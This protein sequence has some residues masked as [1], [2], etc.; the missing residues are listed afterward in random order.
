MT[1]LLA[2]AV[3]FLFF[4]KIIFDPNNNY[5]S[6]D[7]DGFKAYYGAIY[8]AKYDTSLMRMNGM[9][10][11]YGEMVFFTGSQPAVVNVVKFISAHFIDI[12]DNIVGIMN[13]LMIFSIVAAAGFL[14]LVFFELN[15]NWWYASV[16]SAG[17]C[18][19]S[20]QIARFGG[21]FSLS[22]MFW[23]PFMLF[24]VLRF[25]KKP[26][27]K[28]AGLIA[29]VTFFSGAMHMY[30]Y[31]FNGFIIGLYLLAQLVN[32]E[33]SFGLIK[34]FVYFFIQ[35]IL[36][37][38]IFQW[39]VGG[40][41]SVVDRTSY[42]YGFFAYRGHP[43]GVLLPSGKPYGFVPEVITVFKHVPWESLSFIGVSALVGFLVGMVVFVRKIVVRKNAFKITDN[44]VLNTFFW[45]SFIALLFSFGIPFI[46]GLEWM[47][48]YVG[49]FRQLR[50][51]ARFSWLFY[52]VLNI[53]VFYALYRKL[54]ENNKS[55][56][57]KV[58]TVLA[59]GFLLFDGYWNI[60]MNSRFIQNRNAEMEDVSNSLPQNE[61]VSKIKPA[62]YQAILPIPYFHVGS[63][64]IWI[65]SKNNMQ[66][67]T[68]IASLKT[69]LP[70]TA[71]QLSRTS[72]SQTYKNYTLVTEPFES[73]ALLTD[74]PAS[75]P[76]LLL[77]N[78]D[79]SPN[80]DEQRL[81]RFS[82]PVFK[83]D[84]VEVKSLS[85][86]AL[87]EMR[88]NYVSEIRQ[89]ISGKIWQE[90]QGVEVSDSSSAFIVRNFDD[91]KSDITYNG[92]GAL[93][94]STGHWKNILND[95]LKADAGKK[96]KVSFWMYDYSKD[97]YLRTTIEL[98]QRNPETQEVTNY[99]YSDA[100]RHIKGFDG[101]WALIEISIEARNNSELI[102][103]S[104]KNDVLKNG[105]RLIID[106]LLVRESGT[107]ILYS[108]GEVSFFNTRQLRGELFCTDNIHQKIVR[109]GK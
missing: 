65:E 7:G 17:I 62:D 55:N 34:G 61:W 107:D 80:E 22:W 81:I 6:A 75:K 83:N 9:N 56:L 68:M 40:Y 99:F 46:F 54:V 37:F 76:F 13:L 94:Y 33:R 53:V 63:E 109:E 5:Y 50:A 12:S 98:V 39:L 45:T 79:Y 92:E 28:N 29:L 70:T 16:V 2:T 47:V 43:A 48:D 66:E 86:E 52:Y 71:V 77:I 73:Y 51:L 105:T 19:L 18:M 82:E 78:G 108:L 96:Y 10:Y 35:L 20:P 38:L 97:G 27:Y 4:G 14:F 49:P 106:E 89:K 74:L 31:G 100:H 15:V 23:I 103:I 64:N 69:G 30:F 84:K 8:H 95:T 67:M 104:V 90:V 58:L 85:I 41:D 11:P 24:L 72:I 57:W 26:G 91:Q 1:V 88:G 25:H 59:V 3:V 102:S 32:K 87:Q 36:P 101:K 44:F 60:Y 21:H 42:P 93:H